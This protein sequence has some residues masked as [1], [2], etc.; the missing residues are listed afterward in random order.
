MRGIICQWIK[1]NNTK[2]ITVVYK[3]K[4]IICL[5]PGMFLSSSLKE[6]NKE[7][8]REGDKKLG[9]FFFFNRKVI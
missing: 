8:R 9:N 5:V 4:S 2:P 1:Q 3:R 7:G 6:G